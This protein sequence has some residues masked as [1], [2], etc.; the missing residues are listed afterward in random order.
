MLTKMLVN[1]TTLNFMT[2]GPPYTMTV[3][4]WT[5]SQSVLYLSICM[6]LVGLN[7]VFWNCAYVFF[8]LRKKL[9]E[10]RAIVATIFCLLIAY[11]LTYPWPF[12]GSTIA[13]SKVS[14]NET[15]MVN[16]HMGLDVPDSDIIEATGCNPSFKWCGETPA[17]NMIVFLGSLIIVLGFA[18]PLCHINLDILFSKILGNIR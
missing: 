11:L 18:L 13:Y 16:L 2:I 6:G 10:R 4:Q 3:F 14:Y 12:L 7:I 5:S 8:D 9:S 17:V 1:L 15:T